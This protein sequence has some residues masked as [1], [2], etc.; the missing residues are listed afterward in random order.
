VAGTEAMTRQFIQIRIKRN[1][2]FTGKRNSSIAGWN[3]IL[4]EMGLLGCV[5]AEQAR[6]RWTNMCQKYKVAAFCPYLRSRENCCNLHSE[7]DRERVLESSSSWVHLYKHLVKA[8][9]GFMTAVAGNR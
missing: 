1:A 7:I 8:L 2:I 5:T 6:K 3:H 4:E 9:S